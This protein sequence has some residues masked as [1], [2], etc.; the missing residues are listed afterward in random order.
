[1]SAAR[2]ASV[3]DHRSRLGELR[4]DTWWRAFG[5]DDTWL[6]VMADIQ[7]HL[8]ADTGADVVV[9]WAQ[10]PPNGDW[11]RLA[12]ELPD[13]V[14]LPRRSR[15]HADLERE[16]APQRVL[17]ATVRGPYRRALAQAGVAGGWLLPLVA[18]ED[19]VG[20]ETWVGALGLGW[21]QEPPLA[22]P[23]LHV[24]VS[25]LWYLLRQ[26]VES[27]YTEAV[28]EEAVSLGV[29]TA[30][31]E[32]DERLTVMVE[33]LGGDHW[34]LYRVTR[35]GAGEPHLS[36]VAERGAMGDRGRRLV[37]FMREDPDHFR[38]SALLRAAE[39]GY[40]MFIADTKTTI[41]Q[42]PEAF[43]GDPVRSGLVMP[44]GERGESGVGLLGVYWREP[45]GW[46]RFGLS[47][48]P[49]DA[50]RRV[51]ADW[52]QG[53]HSAQDALRDALTGLYNRRGMA[54]AW[55]ETLAAQASGLLGVIDLDAFSAVNNRWGHLMGDEVL[56]VVAHTLGSLAEAE[57]GWC[58]RWGGDEFVLC[59]PPGRDWAGVGRALEGALDRAAEASRW[60]QRVRASG[61]AARWSRARCDFGQTFARADRAL[62]RAKRLGGGRFLVAR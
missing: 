39:Q 26:R 58:G 20:R 59:L 45:E 54:R 18:P 35:D 41:Y 42:I 46:R 12:T 29:P 19:A 14:V 49:W 32:W 36:L 5:R 48:Q 52:W 16:R 31:S 62:Y 61:G 21:R 43:G 15:P 34:S 13:V 4:F 24:V 25:G 56:R 6:S 9:M 57:G 30:P 55:E 51:A 11:V 60:P 28:L 33:R 27:T 23:P 38:Q 7:R 37:A 10:L 1:M 17:T 40:N 44:L 8:R 47:M 2:R 22:P 50:F 3:S 53:M